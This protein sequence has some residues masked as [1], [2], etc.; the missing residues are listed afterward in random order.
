MRAPRLRAAFAVAAVASLVVAGCAE[1]DRDDSGSG[2]DKTLV[3]GAAGDAKVLDPT[4]ASDGETFRVLRQMYEGLVRSEEG[5]TKP[6]AGLAESWSSDAAG[7][8]WTFKLRKG[9]KF[10]DG[11]DFNG[12]A[13]CVNFNRWYNAKGLMQSPDV[14]AY[15]QDIFG[16]FAKNESDKLPESLFKSCSAP[17]AGTAVITISRVT[18]KFPAALMLPAFS[19]SSPEALKKYNADGLGGTA[20]SVT[21]P[22]Y[23]TGHPVGTGPF[24][25]VKW[26]TANKSVELERNDAYYGEKA[27]VKKLIFKTIS[28]VNARKQA[29]KNGEIQGYDLVDPADIPGLKSD[30]F[31]ILPRPAFNV[32]YL[33]INQSGPGKAATSN[34]KV[35]QAIAHAINREAIVKA[36]YPDGSSVAINFQPPGLEGYNDGVTKYEYS[37]EKA[38]Q[39][40]AEAGVTNLK[41]K[42]HYPTE[43]T[44]PYM[45][46]PKDIYELIA[47]DLTKAGITTEAVP[48][49]WNPDYLNAV[50]TGADHDLHL[51]GW[52]GDY[53]DA[54]NFIGTFFDRQKDEW[55]FNNPTLFEAFK[56]ADSEP[57][58]TKRTAQYKEINKQVMDFL[59]GVPIAHGPPSLVFNKSVSGIK[60]SPLTDERFVTAEVK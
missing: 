57:D 29:L 23:A 11:T 58:A 47:A 20:D 2:S 10:H 31:N 15:W 13:V 16:G 37:T 40:L 39:L 3:F 21:Y 9:V 42:F 44:R 52:T 32:L 45:P 4:F 60:A 50:Q 30:G 26:D 53:G 24:K 33:A 6:V 12:E 38:K 51:L 56:K 18:S 22:E 14:T 55:G 43:V 49:K 54:Y 25:F 8:V 1:S 5:G 17:D 7:L 28:D 46:A 41:L 19:I 59:P 27:K 34:V 35:R 36:K 48:L